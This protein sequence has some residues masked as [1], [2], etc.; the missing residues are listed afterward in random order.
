[1]TAADAAE[2]FGLGDVLAPPEPVARGAMGRVW[3]VVTASGRWAVKELFWGGDAAA[4]E[5]DVAFQEAA[6]AAGVRLPRP[7][8]GAG[9][10]AVLAELDG[11]RWRAYEWVDLAPVA[12]D[13]AARAANAAEVG[14]VLARMHRVG[15]TLPWPRDGDDPAVHPW[16]RT[17][18]WPD[19]WP[20][21]ADAADRA[22]APWAG[23]LRAFLPEVAAL[24]QLI[25]AARWDA[26]IVCHRDLT[27]DNLLAGPVVI[28]WEDAGLCDPRQE[29]ASVAYLWGGPDAAGVAPLLR[30]YRAGGGPAELAPDDP[31][32]FAMRAAIWVNYLAVSVKGAL[33]AEAGS[34]TGRD[35]PEG[36]DGDQRAF[37]RQVVEDLLDRPLLVASLERAAAAVPPA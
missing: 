2:F 4:A 11:V 16:Y 18:L 22:G 14:D 36:T 19:G 15:A 28:D 25:A 6:L 1:M 5:R 37:V 17:S 23:R 29:L 10:G 35:A 27:P 12:P 9:S 33:E 7:V 3:K 8:R 34:E 13:A 32:A 31:G 21:L 30:A 24:Q 26:A 20:G